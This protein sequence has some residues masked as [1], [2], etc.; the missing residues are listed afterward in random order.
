M[1]VY[2]GF[3]N[4]HK[5]NIAISFSKLGKEQHAAHSDTFLL[6]SQDKI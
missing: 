1:F 6:V 5:L 4:C 3:K 2:Y